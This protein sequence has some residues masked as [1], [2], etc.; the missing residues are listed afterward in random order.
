VQKAVEK[1]LMPAI[2]H[3]DAT[4]CDTDTVRTSIEKATAKIEINSKD[5][6]QEILFRELLKR[7]KPPAKNLMN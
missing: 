3:I 5:N 6:P 4:L 1:N 7:W 2:D